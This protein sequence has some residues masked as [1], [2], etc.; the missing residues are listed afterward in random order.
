MEVLKK[1]SGCIV[2]FLSGVLGLVLSL[3]SGMVVSSAVEALNKSVQASDIITD[4]TLGTQAQ[5]LQIAGEF[6]FLKTVAIIMLVVSILLIVYSVVEL[7]KNVNV[8]KSSSKAFEIVGMVL[9]TMLLITAILLMIASNG[10]AGAMA[11]KLTA[12]YTIPVTVSIGLYQP[13]MLA[14]AIIALII[15]GIFAILKRKDA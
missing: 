6:G 1:W 11:T 3:C 5:Q 7:L 15:N 8:I 4:T 9:G 2:S 12:V 13:F 10:Y 14:V